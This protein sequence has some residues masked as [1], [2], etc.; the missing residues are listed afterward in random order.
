MKSGLN[1]EAWR[2]QLYDYNDQVLLQ[3]LQYGF[4]LSIKDS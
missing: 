2:R 4:P 1:I 3:Y